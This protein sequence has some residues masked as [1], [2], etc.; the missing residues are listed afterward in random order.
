MSRQA[1]NAR[2]G[3]NSNTTSCA[4]VVEV[5]S[6]HVWIRNRRA[7][8]RSSSLHFLQF[9]LWIPCPKLSLDCLWPI[10]DALSKSDFD[11]LFKET[12]FARLAARSRRACVH[13]LS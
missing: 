4:C 10:F 13:I 5:G 1:E 6:G 9:A 8:A 2:G 11:F 12:S 3:D 7:P